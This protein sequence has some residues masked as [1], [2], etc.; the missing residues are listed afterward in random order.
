M[1]I[2]KIKVYSLHPDVNSLD[3]FINHY[4]FK[5][6]I[7]KFNFVWDK[8]EPQYLFVSEHYYLSAEIFK[9]F[10]KYWS[11]NRDANC[12]YISYL[13]EAMKPDFNLFDYGVSFDEFAVLGDR[14][15]R[16]LPVEQ[17]FKDFVVQDIK[18]P[19]NF[20]EAR[21]ILNEKIKFCNFLYSHA[22]KERDEIF[23]LLSKYKKIDALGRRFHNT[24][25]IPT[26]FQDH[27]RETTTLKLPY[28]FSIT[29]ENGM[30]DGYTTEKILTSLQANT[31]PIYWGNKKI[32]KDFNA[33]TFINANDY[34]TLDELIQKV[35][36]IDNHDDEWIKMACEPIYTEEQK[37]E[38]AIR[39]N[40]Y[41]DFFDKIFSSD[42]IS[43]KR[44]ESTYHM[45]LYQNWFM[46]VNHGIPLYRKVVNKLK[47]MLNR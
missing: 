2:G 28:K 46:H 17:H 15:C 6:F 30:G 3:D 21:K 14:W 25:F 12:V 24:E 42:V 34:R 10:K 32:I 35:I 1:S 22:Y 39:S 41:Y 8:K 13:E 19:K 47:W 16:L 20:E 9:E 43:A 18:R 31:I 11:P 33:K 7:G 26:G 40:K 29:G 44:L 37:R 36:Y 38:I 4:N 23:L 5:P 27:F 45:E